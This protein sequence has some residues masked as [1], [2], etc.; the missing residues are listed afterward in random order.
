[1]ARM[2]TEAAA[3]AIP[4]ASSFNLTIRPGGVVG[5]GPTCIRCVMAVLAMEE[6]QHCHHTHACMDLTT[7]TWRRCCC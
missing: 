5:L 6:G 1:M 4:T 2:P 7:F 3:A